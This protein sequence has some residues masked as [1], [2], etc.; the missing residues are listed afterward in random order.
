M[1]SILAALVVLSASAGHAEDSDRA[2]FSA[3]ELKNV[4]RYCDVSGRVRTAKVR[5]VNE[6]AEKLMRGKNIQRTN[7]RTEEITRGQLGA[8]KE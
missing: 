5:C 2:K 8:P 1:R 4:W 7:A 6:Q 3:S